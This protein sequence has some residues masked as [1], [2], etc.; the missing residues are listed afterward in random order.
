M[1]QADDMPIKSFIFSDFTIS[2]AHCR[3]L[4]FLTNHLK[5]P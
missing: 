5:N 1:T 3:V 2:A 4:N